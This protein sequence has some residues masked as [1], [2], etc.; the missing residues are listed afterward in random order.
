MS[1]GAKERIEKYRPR[2]DSTM[3]FYF[4]EDL[5]KLDAIMKNNYPPDTPEREYAFNQ[6]HGDKIQL[7]QYIAQLVN[8][9]VYS[10]VKSVDGLLDSREVYYLTE[11]VIIKS[12]D[13]YLLDWGIKRNKIEGA[14]LYEG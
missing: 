11:D 3:A 8:T 1:A 13:S 9:I 14:A 2:I 4:R 6:A 7:R 10:F 5:E 12:I